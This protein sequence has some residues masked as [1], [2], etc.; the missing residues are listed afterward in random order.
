MTMVTASPA[1]V[2]AGET[3]AVTEAATE[4]GT[5]TYHISDTRHCTGCPVLCGTENAK[6]AG[7]TAGADLP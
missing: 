1:T 4:A 3:E 2:M 5:F 7:G 6:E